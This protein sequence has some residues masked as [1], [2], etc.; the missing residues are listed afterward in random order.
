MTP[1]IRVPKFRG[2]PWSCQYCSFFSLQDFLSEVSTFSEHKER[3]GKECMG[4]YQA[5]AFLKGSSWGS[6]VDESWVRGRLYRGSSMAEAWDL[7]MILGEGQ[8]PCGQYW[9]MS[10]IKE[11]G[12]RL[13]LAL[14]LIAFSTNF[15]QLFFSRPRYSI[16]ALIEGLSPSLNKPNESGLFWSP[17]NIKLKEDGM[18]ILKVRSP[19]LNFLLL[20]L[21]IVEVWDFW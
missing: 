10:R 16:W 8:L 11:K 14:A 9:S 2:R 21:G 17:I 19:I 15:F 5:G 3:D 12:W 1:V 20:V 13:D 7:T 6:Q 18:E 4:L